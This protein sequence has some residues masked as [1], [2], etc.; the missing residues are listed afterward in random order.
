VATK[1][2][3]GASLNKKQV[4]LITM[5]GTGDWVAGDTITLTIDSIGFI[6]TIGTLVTDA[7]VAT[8]VYQALTGTTFTDT[9]ASCTIPIADGGGSLIPQ[10]SEF[11]A[12]V[13]SN[14]VTLTS[15]GSGALAGKP[16]TLTS[17]QTVA[18][19]ETAARTASVTPTSQYH[20]N[21]ADNY[22][23]NGLPTGGTDT[24][25]FDNG[26][27]DV[28]WGL[29]YAT[30]LTAI[31]KYKAYS[32]NV[33]LPEV[34]VD[35]SS[36]PYHEYRTPT[37]LTCT[38]CTTAN[39]EIGEGPGS[40]RFKLDTGAGASTINVFGKGNRIE[41]GV[42]CILWKGTNTGNVLNNMA[43]DVG[44]AIFGSETAN[45]ATLVNGDGPNSAASTYCGTGLTFNSATVTVN[46]GTLTTQSALATGKQY[47]GTWDHYTGTITTL[48]VYKGATFIPR[49]AQT[50][51]TATVYGKIDLSKSSGTVTF[52]NLVNLYGDAEINDPNGKATFSA[53]YKLN[54]TAAKVIRPV[55]DVHTIS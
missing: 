12:T 2:W 55:G 38:A 24:L 21:E 50:I 1:K 3:I 40:S 48:T 45:L 14:V 5:S 42:Q 22:S 23:A 32:G 6:I 31:T 27:V 39:L 4:D 54:S 30:T 7:Q 52:T 33:G 49:N 36:K 44:V 53:G 10:F 16:F 34:N 26:N 17:T 51:T 11:A 13:A 8:T 37:Y 43:G 9:T 41:Q 47:A 35:S 18:G 28:R 20:A 19:D 46:G 15:N 25:I 29:D